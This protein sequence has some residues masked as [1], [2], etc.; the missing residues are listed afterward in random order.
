MLLPLLPLMPIDLVINAYAAPAPAAIVIA[1]FSDTTTLHTFINVGLT[2]PFIDEWEPVAN[3]PSLRRSIVPLEVSNV[4]DRLHGRGCHHRLTT[5][6][7]AV[8]T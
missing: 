7:F 5:M 2:F 1:L 6:I 8:S 4:L 3:R